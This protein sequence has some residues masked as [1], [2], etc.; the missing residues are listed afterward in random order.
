MV[1]RNSDIIQEET[2]KKEHDILVK[3]FRGLEGVLKSEIEALGFTKIFE[4]TRGVIVTADPDA[5]YKLNYL[6][7]TALKVLVNIAKFKAANQVELYEQVKKIDWTE[8]MDVDQTFAID[9]NIFNSNFNNSM[10]VS[11]KTKDAIVDQFRE[12]F[13]KRP[14]VNTENPDV[15][16]NV[17]VNKDDCTISLDSSGDSLH[18]RGYRT[19]Q[20][21][22]PLSEV[23]AAGLV[24][25]TGWDKQTDIIDPMCGS[26]TILTEAAMIATNTPAGYFRE[27]F[28]FET[29]KSF[30]PELFETIKSNAESRMTS[31]NCSLKGYD[32]DPRATNAAR[33]N[34]ANAGFANDIEIG[35]VA[36]EALKPDAENGMLIMN[37]PYGERLQDEEEV[38]EM[39]SMIGDQLK[40]RWQGYTAWI[41]SSNLEALKFVGLKTSARY[42]VYNGPLECKF[43]KY[44]LYGGSKKHK[45]QNT[46]E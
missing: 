25:L 38:K 6:C 7:R 43:Q 35:K 8:F 4:A 34:I 29:W 5:I 41:I 26:G 11:Q 20:G 14:N 22:A 13:D 37:P 12:K 31:L 45:Y 36:F 19:A 27:R 18:M 16:I 39:Y 40:N 32:K 42:T 10:F 3:T 1:I 28:G 24:M 23:L 15:R 9:S 44:E 17:H 46:E 21:K 30:K 33:E 2:L